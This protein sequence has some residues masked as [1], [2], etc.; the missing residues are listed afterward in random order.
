MRRWRV[1]LKIDGF[2]DKDLPKKNKKL[3]QVIGNPHSHPGDYRRQMRCLPRMDNCS[4]RR[5]AGA[6]GWNSMHTAFFRQRKCVENLD[7]LEL[8]E[9]SFIRDNKATAWIENRSLTIGGD[10]EYGGCLFQFTRY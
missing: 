3:F 7:E 8:I 1:K 10:V 2:D 4:F 9:F 6:R 5:P